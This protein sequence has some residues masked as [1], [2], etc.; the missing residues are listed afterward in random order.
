[1]SVLQSPDRPFF[2]PLYLLFGVD[3]VNETEDTN[4]YRDANYVPYNLKLIHNERK[5]QGHIFLYIMD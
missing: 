2:I 1:M 3:F 5:F 4:N